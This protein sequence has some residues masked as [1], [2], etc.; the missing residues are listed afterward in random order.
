VLILD[1]LGLAEIRQ[2]CELPIVIAA[3]QAP[4]VPQ[5]YRWR[6]RFR[7]ERPHRKNRTGRSACATQ[8]QNAGRC[9]R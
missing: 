8:K 6:V 9:R 5:R 1:G 4:R 2:F 7:P 3:P